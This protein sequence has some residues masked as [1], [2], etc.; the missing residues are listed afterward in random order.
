MLPE[1]SRFSPIFKIKKQNTC[2]KRSDV[3]DPSTNTITT[4][5]VS[6]VTVTANVASPRALGVSTPGSVHVLLFDAV[7]GAAVADTPDA[8]ADATE[9]DGFLGTARRDLA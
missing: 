2:M 6:D 9:H 1:W 3:E 8:D 7:I 4:C 5:A